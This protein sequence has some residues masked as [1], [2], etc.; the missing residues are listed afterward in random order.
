M[1]LDYSLWIT[2]TSNMLIKDKKNNINKMTENNVN[3]I[4]FVNR[5]EQEGG[6]MFYSDSFRCNSTAG[7]S[8]RA[9][10]FMEASI[11]SNDVLKTHLILHQISF[12]YV[13]NMG[14]I[15]ENRQNMGYL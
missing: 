13:L 12:S 8:H 10:T 9:N 6:H 2:L 11:S 3:S 15:H 14:M 7:Q 1:H 4:R 5:R